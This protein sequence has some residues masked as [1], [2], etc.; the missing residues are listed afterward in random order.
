[1]DAKE[2]GETCAKWDDIAETALRASGGR[3]D[4]AANMIARD[5]M[6][7]LMDAVKTGDVRTIS[8][9]LVNHSKA[10]AAVSLAMAHMRATG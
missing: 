9:V 7:E 5:V 2:F 3:P 4:I 1:M 8:D 10:I 6:A